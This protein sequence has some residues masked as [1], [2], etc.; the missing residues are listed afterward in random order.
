MTK[1]VTK[2]VTKTAIFKTPSSSAIHAMAPDLGAMIDFWSRQTEMAI[3]LN[4]QLMRMTLETA[5]AYSS[6]PISVTELMMTGLSSQMAEA[7]PAPS[8]PP[9]RATPKPAV[10]LVPPPAAPKP[11][12]KPAA[13]VQPAASAVAKPAAA[14]KPAA[15]TRPLASAPADRAAKMAPPSAK[16]QKPA[17]PVA[18]KPAA[19]PAKPAQPDPRPVALAAPRGGKADDLTQLKGVGPKLATQLADLG[20]FHFDQIAN[21]SDANLTWLDEALSGPKGAARRNGWV[22]QAQRLM[23]PTPVAKSGKSAAPAPSAVDKPATKR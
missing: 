2:T 3:D 8:T 14:V 6:L 19:A 17:K 18:A 12:P 10:R 7:V 9:V 23:A 16:P 15:A 1:P 22:A 5:Q 21:L 20:L 13:A 11:T 4:A